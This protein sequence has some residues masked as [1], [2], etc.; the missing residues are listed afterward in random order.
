M[1]KPEEIK[2]V[3]RGVWIIV[4]STDIGLFPYGEREVVQAKG[5]VHPDEI[6]SA[7]LHACCGLRHQ[8]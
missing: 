7:G 2:C 6:F 3:C 4:G 1:S 5:K 8:L